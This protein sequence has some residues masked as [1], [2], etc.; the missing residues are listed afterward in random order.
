MFIREKWRPIRSV[1]SFSDL[2]FPLF[3]LIA[4]YVIGCLEY[5]VL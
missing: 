5:A 2:H 4:R 1:S 3:G